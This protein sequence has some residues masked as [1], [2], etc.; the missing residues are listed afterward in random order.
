MRVDRTDGERGFVHKRSER[1]VRD[2]HSDLFALLAR[3][4]S[5]RGIGVIEVKFSIT[6]FV[7]EKIRGPCATSRIVECAAFIF[8]MHEVVGNKNF[9]AAS[10]RCGVEK[11]FSIYAKNI[12][13][14]D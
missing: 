1:A 9:V 2:G 10:V 13:I 4:G 3:L 5:R 11:I 8:P 12:W 7:I 14:G 6:T